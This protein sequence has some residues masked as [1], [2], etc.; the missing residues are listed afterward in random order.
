MCDPL[1]RTESRPTSVPFVTIYHVLQLLSAVINFKNMRVSFS[2]LES[3]QQ[4]PQKYKFSEIDR[5][6]VPKSAE[7]VFGS[8]VHN[9]L[10]YFHGSSPSL[11]TI[12]ELVN[13]FKAVWSK[14]EAAPWKTP[15]EEKSWLDQGVAL[16]E[17]YYAQNAPR[18]FNIVDLETRFEA[19]LRDDEGESHALTGIID[20][21]DKLEDGSWEIIDYKTTKRM[22]AQ[23]DVDSSLQLSIYLLGVTARWPNLKIPQIKL[24][25]YFL[26]HGEKLTAAADENRLPATRRKVLEMLADIQKRRA[27]NDFPAIPTALCGWCG[28]QKL[29]PM[30]K[31]KYNKSEI[32]NPKSETDIEEVIK[33]FFELKEQTD[34]A[35]GRMAELKGAI[36]A[37]CDETGLERVFGDAG[38]ITRTLQQRFSY[39]EGRL[40]EILSGQGLWESVLAFDSKKLDKMAKSLPRSVRE[41]IEKTKTLKTEFKTLKAVPKK[42]PA[43]READET[44][45]KT[46]QTV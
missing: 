12:E 9:A 27:K 28:Y 46:E 11:P 34:R 40:K 45:N 17:K 25:L 29:C 30:W 23:R 43:G 35:D 2:S 37:Y 13:Y 36:N 39:D 15:E 8:A 16:L 10:K 7:Q 38:Y 22:P 6:R 4:C 18:E 1:L 42:S 33:E 19:P 5:I 44:E 20:R 24:S 32:R 21:I 3:F 26:K 31:H 41:E 14:S